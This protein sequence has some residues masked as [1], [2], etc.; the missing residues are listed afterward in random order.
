MTLLMLEGLAWL[1]P[2][3]FAIGAGA[4]GLAMIVMNGSPEAADPWYR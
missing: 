4:L 2:R 3:G 1:P